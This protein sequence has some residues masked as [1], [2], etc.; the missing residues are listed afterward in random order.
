MVSG[1]T[2]LV[3]VYGM[4]EILLGQRGVLPYRCCGCC[5]G[6][7]LV[8][9]GLGRNLGVA[10]DERLGQMFAVCVFPFFPLVINET[11]VHIKVERKPNVHMTIK[12]NQQLPSKKEGNR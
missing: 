6:S 12:M 3:S 8:G 4:R 10:P 7:G 11:T 5:T 9:Q 1:E 2:V